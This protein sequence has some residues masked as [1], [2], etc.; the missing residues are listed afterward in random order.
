MRVVVSRN[1]CLLDAISFSFVVSFVP[2][3]RLLSSLFG[4]HAIVSES[5]W[6]CRCTLSLAKWINLAVIVCCAVLWS[7]YGLGKSC[8]E[9]QQTGLQWF[10][11]VNL[12]WPWKSAVLHMVG[13]RAQCGGVFMK[14]HLHL[15]SCAC[16]FPLIRAAFLSLGFG[17]P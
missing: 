2:I 16:V 17:T 14:A 7:F 13:M 15:L 3:D 5:F 8:Y 4:F 11:Y 1:W 12:K 6:P 9:Q 10:R